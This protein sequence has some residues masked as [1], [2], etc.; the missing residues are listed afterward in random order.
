MLTSSLG[1]PYARDT[2]SVLQ[3]CARHSMLPTSDQVSGTCNIR[4]C[5]QDGITLHTPVLLC[6]EMST[7]VIPKPHLSHIGDTS[8]DHHNQQHLSHVPSQKVTRSRRHG[9]GSNTHVEN[10]AWALLQQNGVRID[11]YP[12]VLQRALGLDRKSIWTLRLTSRSP[13]LVLLRR[14][15]LGTH[16]WRT[17]TNRRRIM[18]SS[19]AAEAGFTY[20]FL[21]PLGSLAHYG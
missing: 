16:A 11:I 9:S 19:C 3:I 12:Q 17:P 2:L 20:P 10:T 13:I 6:Q 7:P 18:I 15:E 21:V 4:T 14:T 8:C 5:Y 1:D